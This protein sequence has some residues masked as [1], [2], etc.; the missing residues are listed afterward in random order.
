[1]PFTIS[2]IAAVLPAHR[3]LSRAHLFTAA[4]IGSMVPDFGLLWPE[5]PGRLQTHSVDAL[6]SFCLPVGLLAFAIVVF[7]IK[8][9]VL[10]VLPDGAYLRVRAADAAGPLKPRHWPLA[11][12]VIVLGAVTHIVWDGFTHESARGVRMFPVLDEYG[13]AIDGQPVQL[14]WLLQYASSFIGL[15]VVI[16]ALSLWLRHART[17]DAPIRRPLASRERDLWIS[18]Y[19]LVP[20]LLMTAVVWRAHH[21]GFRPLSLARATNTIAILGMRASVLS[22]LLMSLLLR[23]RLVLV[24]QSAGS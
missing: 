9:A 20:L 24:R 10:E 7:L 13:A 23:A 4:V 1:V 17:P 8:P 14:Y 16:A 18:L 22:L 2:H 15:V 5:T 3:V 21:G 11:A 12:A 6:L 19:L